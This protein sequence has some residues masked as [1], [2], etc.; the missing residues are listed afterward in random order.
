M[1]NNYVEAYCIHFN[2]K[3]KPTKIQGENLIYNGEENI[4]FYR[5][6]SEYVE[7]DR[8][9]K[10]SDLLQFVLENVEAHKRL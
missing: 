1:N 3:I 10:K 9:Y 4:G 5:S 8:S 6:E 2:L 7:F